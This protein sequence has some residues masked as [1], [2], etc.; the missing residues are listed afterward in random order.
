M[1]N[2][3]PIAIA[4]AAGGVKLSHLVTKATRLQNRA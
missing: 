4:C 2:N 1:L 3:K